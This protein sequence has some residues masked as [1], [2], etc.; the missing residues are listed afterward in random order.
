MWARTDGRNY[1][2]MM[3]EN[4]TTSTIQLCPVRLNRK[5]L[6]Q[7]CLQV[8]FGWVHVRLECFNCAQAA[9]YLVYFNFTCLNE[10]LK[11]INDLFN[12]SVN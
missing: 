3:W 8:E 9:S 6:R 7:Q 2:A 5:W 11:D 1:L 10:E 4:S 12:E